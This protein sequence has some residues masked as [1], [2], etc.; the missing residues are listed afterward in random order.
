MCNV[1]TKIIFIHLFTI[2]VQLL[3]SK[4]Q[5]IMFGN[6]IHESKC[7]RYKCVY[8]VLWSLCSFPNVWLSTFGLQS[9]K[10]IIF[11][12]MHEKN[13]NYGKLQN[14]TNCIIVHRNSS[15]I[16]F[17]RQT[18]LVYFV[19]NEPFSHNCDDAFN[20]H[21]HRK[22]SKL[23]YTC[24]FFLMFQY[25]TLMRGCFLCSVPMGWTVN[26]TTFSL[27]NYCCFNI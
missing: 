20:S 5:I 7:R 15:L 1:C 26:L 14:A 13:Y 25:F 19:V 21:Q 18:L 10:K 8:S 27:K 23:F 22:Y 3:L 11:L 9:Q 16:P 6:C 24:I 4:M 17:L 2:I 12:E